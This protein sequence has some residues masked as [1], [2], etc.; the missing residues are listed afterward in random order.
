MSTSLA[1]SPN[2]TNISN[3][4]GNII[5][6]IGNL[7]FQPDHESEI[8]SK[9]EKKISSDKEKKILKALFD[10]LDGYIVKPIEEG[11]DIKLPILIDREINKYFSDKGRIIWYGS[12]SLGKENISDYDLMFIPDGYVTQSFRMMDMDNMYQFM[13][14]LRDKLN[15]KTKSFDI[16]KILEDAEPMSEIFDT[17]VKIE[18]GEN[19]PLGSGI[20][21]QTFKKY[22]STPKEGCFKLSIIP[23]L[24]IN[25][26][27]KSIT[28]A[29]DENTGV[30][31]CLFRIKYV[32]KQ[33]G[34]IITIPVVDLSYHF[35]NKVNFL[36]DS[37]D[38]WGKNYIEF[39]KIIYVKNRENL[40]TD[41]YLQL[42]SAFKDEDIDKEQVSKASSRLGL[43]SSSHKSVLSSSVRSLTG[44]KKKRTKKTKKVKKLN[45]N[46]KSQ[47][48][49]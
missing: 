31:F 3:L 12:T 40:K 27:A 30:V 33:N 14:S 7:K 24:W 42:I 20:K 18:Y 28:R 49:K 5:K 48:K 19:S 23:Y 41:L 25:N 36:I 15:E 34:E 47:R 8:K 21:N 45:S 2:R 38:N 44:G 17:L 46:N 43:L 16:T 10:S 39:N 6:M 9:D 4:T 32:F 29:D 37:I 26:E 11:R 13:N 1:C 22:I 35:C